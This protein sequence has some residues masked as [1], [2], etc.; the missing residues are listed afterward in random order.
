MVD[1]AISEF[2][3]N[4]KE[5]WLKKAL[6]ASMDES[7]VLEKKQECED[8]FA[9]ANWLPDAA[10]RAGQ[11]RFSSH[12]PTFSHPSAGKNK[13]GKTTSVIAKAQRSADGYLRSGNATVQNDALG[14]A[15]ALDVYKFLTLAMQDG[16]TLLTHIEQNSP[17]ARELLSIPTASYTD[18]RS[19]FLSMV[20]KSDENIVTSAKI[21]QVYFPV[22]DDYHQL[23]L[24]S[25]SGLIY[26][27]RRRI[28]DLRFSEKQKELRKLK[29][30]KEYSEEG[31]KEITVVTTIGYGGTKPQNI[32]VL[33]NQHSGKAHLLSSEPPRLA[34]RDIQFPTRDFFRQT[35]SY[36]RCRDLF[37]DLHR[38]FIRYENNWQIRAERDEYYQAIIDRIVER[39][40]LV[41]SVAQEQFN[42]ET[43]KLDKSQQVWLCVDNAEK[44][45]TEDNWLDSI[46]EQI[47]RY[48]FDGYAKIL[49]KRAFTFSD[50]EFQHIHGQVDK[51]REAL[52]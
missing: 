13:N 44:R 38:L 19:G 24:L 16:D 21:K 35:F 18:L 1:A 14:N 51:N 7:E 4:R 22:D 39:M 26:E 32:S 6:N 31:Y 25:N 41:R 23:S 2:F 36:Y 37:H 45:E 43:R 49:G 20:P 52:R 50:T 8:K 17:L 12:P 9:L 42:P 48:I 28:D 11:I 3:Q 34:A 29:R 46:S 5:G 40:W 33:N 47:A 10:G 30:D 15:A 27:L